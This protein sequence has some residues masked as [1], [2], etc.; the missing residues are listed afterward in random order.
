MIEEFKD[1]FPR[2]TSRQIWRLLLTIKLRYKTYGKLWLSRLEASNYW[3]SERQML[4][5]IDYL[6]DTKAIEKIGMTI[7]KNNWMKCNVYSIWKWFLNWLN[8]VKEYIKK[9]FEYVDPISYVKARFQTKTKYWKLS[10][11]VN[12]NKYIIHLRGDFKNVIYDVWNNC[13]I[14][15]LTLI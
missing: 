13:I 8:K 15:P 11:K 4:K 1:I 2:L 7:S 3:I 10:F 12:W 9:T 5:F 6:R 14:N